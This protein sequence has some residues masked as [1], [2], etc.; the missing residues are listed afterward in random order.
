M[1]PPVVSSILPQVKVPIEYMAPTFVEVILVVNN[2]RIVCRSVQVGANLYKYP[3]YST[4]LL[5]SLQELANE[6]GYGNWTKPNFGTTV[7]DVAGTQEKIN[8][9]VQCTPDISPMNCTDCIRD[10]YSTLKPTKV[11][12]YVL[13]YNCL[14]KYDDGKPI[15]S[16]YA[17]SFMPNYFHVIMVLLG[18]MYFIFM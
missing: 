8:I 18:T 6:A 5:N 9:L 12:G 4:T 1:N 2:A 16:G 11:D 14:L 3:Q 17:A 13:K 7:V 10:M 15:N